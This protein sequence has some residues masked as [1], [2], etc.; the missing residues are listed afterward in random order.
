MLWEKHLGVEADF[1]IVSADTAHAL[2]K[3]NAYL[4]GFDKLDHPLPVRPVEVRA[5]VPIVHK[6]LDVREA[7]LISIS[8]ED[9]LLREDLSR[10]FSPCRYI[11]YF[12]RLSSE[13]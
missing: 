12:T 3:Q 8:S 9:S 5:A 1:K 11:H 6:I 13:Y 4:V 2:G 7:L 10:G